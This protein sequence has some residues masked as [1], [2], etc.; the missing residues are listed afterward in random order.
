[1]ATL[2]TANPVVI[3]VPL[4]FRMVKMANAGQLVVLVLQLASIA[5]A[6]PPGSSFGIA[7]KATCE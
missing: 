6:A 5:I 1:M 7:H 4:L 3:C 2:Y